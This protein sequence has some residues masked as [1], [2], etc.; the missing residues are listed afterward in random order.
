MTTAVATSSHHRSPYMRLTPATATTAGDASTTAMAFHLLE[1]ALD[2][3]AS[4]LAGIGS[5]GA[6]TL[7][8]ISEIPEILS[9]RTSRHPQPNQGFSAPRGHLCLH[10]AHGFRRCDVPGRKG[11]LERARPEGADG[12]R[13]I[14][15]LGCSDWR[16]VLLGSGQR[17]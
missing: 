9:L 17:I 3:G 6:A 2:A 13:R 15:G 5:P 14:A 7:D 16:H 4:R 1:K 12:N 11:R 10:T 8:G